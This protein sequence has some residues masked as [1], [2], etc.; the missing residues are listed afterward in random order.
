MS[1]RSDRERSRKRRRHV[2]IA[3]VSAVATVALV[4]VA[5]VAWAG[6]QF[7]PWLN[8]EEECTKPLELRVIADRAVAA[9]VETIAARYDEREGS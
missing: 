3:G 9:T 8:P 1:R 2:V 4:G 6:G 5:G 7:D